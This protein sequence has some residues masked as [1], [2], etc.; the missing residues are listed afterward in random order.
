M[1]QVELAR[2]MGVSQQAI[3]QLERREADG[4]AT[5]NA[6]EEAADGLDCEFVYALVPRRSI[7]A[8]LEARALRL[9]TRMTGS[10]RHSMRLEDQEPASDLDDRT[11][12]L[13]KELL[14]S[15]ERLWSASLDE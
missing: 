6:L 10:V 9:A 4:S 7:T 11:R 13:A 3:S 14:A 1:S 15:P 5:L 12:A 2:R 8:T